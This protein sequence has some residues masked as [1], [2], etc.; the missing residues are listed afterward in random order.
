M[1]QSMRSQRAGHGLATEQQQEICI[2]TD[3]SLTRPLGI[4]IQ[5]PHVYPNHPKRYPV[6]HG[7]KVT[8]GEGI[9]KCM[10]SVASR[11]QP[12]MVSL[13]R[14]GNHN[15]QWLKDLTVWPEL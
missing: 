15:T 3:A 6:L 1:L 11:S 2:F 9:K 10:S 14:L 13:R 5:G 4:R 7:H 8:V 12:T